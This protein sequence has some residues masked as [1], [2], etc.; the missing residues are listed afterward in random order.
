MNCPQLKQAYDRLL[1]L[2]GDFESRLSSF[3]AMAGNTMAERD[4]AAA[5]LKKLQE[6]IDSH[7]NINDNIKRIIL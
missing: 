5:G 4:Q 6:E 1:L 2:R 7:G 3:R